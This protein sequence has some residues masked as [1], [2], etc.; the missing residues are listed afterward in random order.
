MIALPVFC[1]LFSITLFMIFT[2]FFHVF[3]KADFLHDTLQTMTTKRAKVTSGDRSGEETG[4]VQVI[5]Y[6]SS[7]SVC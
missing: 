3:S 7:C 5:I 2:S 1:F 6:D 4:A